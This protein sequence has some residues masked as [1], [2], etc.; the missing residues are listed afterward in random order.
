LIKVLVGLLICPMIYWSARWVESERTHKAEVERRR[1]AQEKGEV[2]LPPLPWPVRPTSWVFRL[3]V[4]LLLGIVLYSVSS[5]FPLPFIAPD[6][7]PA[8]VWLGLIGVLMLAL[9]SS[10]LPAGMGLLTLTSGFELFFDVM[11]PG[12]VD[13]AAFAVVNLLMGLA[14]SHLITVEAHTGQELRSHLH[15]PGQARFFSFLAR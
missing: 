12:L 3:L 8:C 4:V 5:A 10:P 9:T 6:I 1:I 11:S 7:A 15:R 14:I 13:I 2:P